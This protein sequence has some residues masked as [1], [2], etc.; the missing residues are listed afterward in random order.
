MMRSGNVY[1]AREA[2]CLDANAVVKNQARFPHHYCA[3]TVHCSREGQR[4]PPFH[5]TGNGASHSEPDQGLCACRSLG[6]VA[7][8]TGDQCLHQGLVRDEDAS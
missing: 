7:D 5:V 8:S 2:V 4:S 3:C 6:F 1:P